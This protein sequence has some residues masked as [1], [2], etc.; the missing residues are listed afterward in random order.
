MCSEKKTKQEQSE[1]ACMYVR[2]LAKEEEMDKILMKNE[3]DRAR[4]SKTEEE[5]ERERKRGKER[6]R[7]RKRK[8]RTYEKEGCQDTYIDAGRE[9]STLYFPRDC[10]KIPIVHIARE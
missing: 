4:Q 5:R 3:E 2:K 1:I 7:E 8:G 6:A 10:Y 9:A